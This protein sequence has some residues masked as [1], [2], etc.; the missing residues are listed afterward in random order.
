MI[1][2]ECAAKQPDYTPPERPVPLEELPCTVC[3]DVRL[4]IAN[5]TVGLPG[6]TPDEAFRL[7]AQLIKADSC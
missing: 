3:A 5:H 1:C 4:C 2:L 6:M 7:I